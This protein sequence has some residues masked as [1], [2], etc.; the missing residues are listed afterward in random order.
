MANDMFRI[1]DGPLVLSVQ[2]QPQ[3]SEHTMEV[4]LGDRAVTLGNE[5]S[6]PTTMFHREG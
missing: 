6:I 4:M 5:A 2:I 3:S 1:E